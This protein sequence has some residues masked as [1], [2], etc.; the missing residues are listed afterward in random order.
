MEVLNKS[1]VHSYSSHGW[2]QD[3]IIVSNE[4]HKVFVP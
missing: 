4:G 3:V 2:Q 1:E